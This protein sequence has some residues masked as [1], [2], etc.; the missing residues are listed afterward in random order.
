MTTCSYA[1]RDTG[2]ERAI[3][4]RLLNIVAARQNVELLRSL[5]DPAQV[6]LDD[7]LRE[8]AAP[9]EPIEDMDPT[10]IAAWD[11]IVAGR[12]INVVVGPPGVG[13]PSSSPIS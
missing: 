10:K 11:S 9:G 13:K 4:R 8:I 5:D 12:S 3:R 7:V 1:R 2:T 6:A